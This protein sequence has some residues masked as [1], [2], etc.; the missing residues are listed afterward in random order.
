MNQEGKIGNYFN[1]V[2]RGARDYDSCLVTLL[3]RGTTI[4]PFHEQRFRIAKGVLE[5]ILAEFISA[6]QKK[7]KSASKMLGKNQ[8]MLDPKSPELDMMEKSHAELKTLYNGLREAIEG[9]SGVL[10]KIRRNFPVFEL[11]FNL[12]Y[13]VGSFISKIEFFKVEEEDLSEGGEVFQFVGIGSIQNKVYFK[14]LNDFNKLYR[15]NIFWVLSLLLRKIL[16]NLLIDIFRKK[17]GIRNILLYYLPHKRRFHNFSILLSN[18]ESKLPDLRYLSDQLN[19]RLIEKLNAYR[20]RGNESAHS[21][22]FLVTKEDID[23]KREE[24]NH[25]IHLLDNILSKIEL[26]S[27]AG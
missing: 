10:A 11:I 13:A 21:I 4:L 8:R 9:D 15:S 18:L 12:N 16:E 26:G 1:T 14:V 23:S 20:E 7:L 25:L 27:E 3:S 19:A 6:L 22:E 2:L 17:Y 5:R 24:I